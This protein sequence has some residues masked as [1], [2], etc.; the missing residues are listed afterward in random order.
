MSVN[1]RS[2]LY[3]LLLVPLFVY[4][5]LPVFGT[6]WHNV[7][8]EHDHVLGIAAGPDA[9]AMATHTHAGSNACV[10]CH[11]NSN[12]LPYTTM[13]AFD[14]ISGLV[15]FTIIMA[16]GDLLSLNPPRGLSMRVVFPALFLQSPL[17]VPLELPPA[18]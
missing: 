3:A 17:L 18:A 9:L 16:A 14:P 6:V 10:L 4:L 1:V 8:P 12:W 7:V 5:L 15:V 2:R 13:H 11:G